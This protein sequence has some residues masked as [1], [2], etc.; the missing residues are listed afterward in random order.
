MLLGA[1]IT[2]HPPIVIP[3]IGKGEESKAEATIN[4]LKEISKEIAEKRPETIIVITPHGPVFS[5]AVCISAEKK[6]K[7][8]FSRFGQGN[9]KFQFDNDY[10][11][12]ERIS[13]SANLEDILVGEIDSRFAK[14]YK[15]PLDIDHGTL[16]PLYFVNQ[17]YADY[18]LIH[19]SMGLL[20]YHE[21][22]KFGM[23][24]NKVIKDSN[25]DIVV[26]AS[27]D[28]SHRLTKDSSNGY[29]PNGKVFDEK[30]VECIRNNQVEE[31]M[32]IPHDL[33]ESA[34]ECGLRPF[35][36]LQGILDGFRVKP[37]VVSYEGPFGVGY[38]TAKYEILG[39][40]DESIYNEL[41]QKSKNQIEQIR[42]NEDAYVKLARESLEYYINNDSTMSVPPN[43]DN[44]LLNNKAGVFVS[45]KKHGQLRGCIGTIEPTKD[46]IALEI[47]YNAV[48]SGTKDNRFNPVEQDELEDLIYSVDVLKKAEPVKTKEELDPKKFGVI[49]AK[50]FRRGLL[51]PNLEG[52]DTV[53]EQLS[54]ALSKAGIRENEDYSIE[55]FEVIRHGSK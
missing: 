7:G 3:Q 15:I 35:I 1:Y 50:G 42:N 33:I 52:V 24:I 31:L 49:V 46:N 36:I 32:N 27:G 28:M 34:G 14:E 19:I 45:I 51:L 10:I 55:K 8:D 41:L 4:G 17:V 6:L 9:L 5:D 22:F 18:K 25:Q 23:C 11:M 38:M 20:P 39:S 13:A 30:L 16:V 44:E 47:I 37:N 53:E 29:S 40:K 2:P 48:S 54:I 43:I 21:L 12:A 26:I